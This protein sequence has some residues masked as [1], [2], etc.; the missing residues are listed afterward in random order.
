MKIGNFL[1]SLLP[2]FGK[3]QVLEDCRLTHGEIKNGTL[4]AYESAA[5]LLKS[6]K[7]K[8]DKLKNQFAMFSRVSGMNGNFVDAVAKGLKQ[9]NENLDAVEDMISKTYN[10]DVAASGLTYLKANLL[11]FVE[12]AG[13]VSKF[14]RKYL[15]YIYALETV[16]VG[17]QESAS[18]SMETMLKA[19]V[20]WLD[21]NFLSFA[22]AFGIVSTP[23]AN[24]R[25]VLG[26]IP[27]IVV[28]ADNVQTL[29]ATMGQSKLDPMQ[30]GLI[31]VWLNPIYH[32]GMV[33]AEWQAARHKEMQ[34]ELRL[35]Q[36]R[37]LNLERV[38]A[39]KPDAKIQKEI[40]WLSSR[41][42]ELSYKLQ[43]MERDNA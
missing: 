40:G 1:A 38:A 11:Q 3:D 43:K 27:D 26:N 4:P 14:A 32:V 29:G 7:F 41:R 6:W 13:F 19:H 31:P 37:K 17:D 22:T 24:L 42:D 34:E 21:A 39:G 16:E 20:E 9:A 5:P 23:T 2:S 10:E 8:S 28:T 33:V 35:I 18:A 12:T 15:D 25:K 36:L 30:F